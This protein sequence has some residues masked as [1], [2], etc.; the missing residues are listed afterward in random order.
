MS[1]RSEAAVERRHV[2][3]SFI[4][5]ILVKAV[6]DLA[7]FSNMTEF[8]NMAS[9]NPRTSLDSLPDELKSNILAYLI[10]SPP[11]CNW[12][13]STINTKLTQT[14]DVSKKPLKSLSLVSKSWYQLVSPILYSSLQLHLHEPPNSSETLLLAP[15]IKSITASL[16]EWL[17]RDWSYPHDIRLPY[18]HVWQDAP[19][20]KAATWTST[21]DKQLADLL[22]FLDSPSNCSDSD[23]V[24][25]LT[26][27]AEGE[28]NDAQLD[29]I[30]DEMHCLIATDAFWNL[31][32]EKLDLDRVT[33]VAPPSKLACLLGS[34]M[35]MQDA[36]AF[37]GMS[38]QLASVWKEPK[39]PEIFDCYHSPPSCD[40]NMMQP[41][42]FVLEP[43]EY[44][45]PAFS[46][47]IYIKP[48]THLA[49]NEG[50]FLEAY[51]SYEYFHKNPPGIL[52]VI[53]NAFRLELDM[54]SVSYKGVFPFASHINAPLDRI[55]YKGNPSN[56]RRIWTKLAPDP[57]D[58]ILDDPAQVGKADISDCWRE[59]ESAYRFLTDPELRGDSDF[60]PP[61]AIHES[62]L[63]M[64]G[65][66][67][68]HVT[69]IKEMVVDSLG[70]VGWEE[71]EKDEWRSNRLL[72]SRQ[73]REDEKDVDVDLW[74]LRIE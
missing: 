17:F 12:D 59:I 18:R 39:P 55:T 42:E 66:G 62:Q 30:R 25:S 13:Q 16:K 40:Y 43:N 6:S 37:P 74:Q 27:V 51:S 41:V 56:V 61:G 8:M 70:S 47:F 7:S 31:V 9:N 2:H 33:V 28:L 1:T 20:P 60:S 63:D 44:G 53:G 26:V 65:Y 46:S 5:I 35:N 22:R 54:W 69:T 49:V 73:T 23:N 64:F 10:A 72:S 3:L 50:S 36:W 24:K 67:D 4:S 19:T 15:R 29:Y 34:S 58:K 71:L 45:R 32:F 68:S 21:L 14:L 52:A 48:W 57:E 38:M 11:S